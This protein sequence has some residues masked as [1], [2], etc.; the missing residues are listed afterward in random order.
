[1]VQAT[2][3]E[4]WNGFQARKGCTDQWGHG[5]EAM[6]GT[7]VDS[8]WGFLSGQGFL[9]PRNSPK[10]KKVFDLNRIDKEWNFHSHEAHWVSHSL[11]QTWLPPF[12]IIFKCH[13]EQSLLGLQPSRLRC[14]CFP[15][16]KYQHTHRH[17]LLFFQHFGKWSGSHRFLNC[18]KMVERSK[19]QTYISLTFSLIN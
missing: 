3:H 16:S 7:L 12:K 19:S 15:S 6:R 1:M 9:K 11:G 17:F 4:Q 8:R 2:E 18:F 5:N 14:S 10:A 13:G